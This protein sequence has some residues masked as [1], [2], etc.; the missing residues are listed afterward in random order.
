MPYSRDVLD[1]KR[2]LLNEVTSGRTGYFDTVKIIREARKAEDGKVPYA[3]MGARAGNEYFESLEI[4]GADINANYLGN[5]S[6]NDINTSFKIG[7][8]YSDNVIDT[9]A[10]FFVSG[11]SYGS[12]KLPAKIALHLALNRLAEEEGIRI[13]MNTGEGG[14]LP[15]E[16]YSS[17][18][19]C[20]H[21]AMLQNEAIIDYTDRLLKAHN[22]ESFGK[23]Q[24]FRRLYPLVTQYASGR[25]WRDP[26]YL[27]NADAIEIKIGQGA[28]IGHGG[29]LPAEKVTD[30]V[31]ENRGIPSYRAAHSPSRH[32]DIL[33][34]EDLVAKVLEL[35]EITDWKKP[36]IVKIGASRVYDDVEI[37]LKSYA[38]AI[39]IDGY[40]GG[41]GAA[42]LEVRDGIGINTI[43]ALELAKDAITDYYSIHGRKYDHGGSNDNSSCKLLVHGGVWDSERIAKCIALGADGVGIGTGFMLTMG[44][45][46]VQD[47]YTNT[48]PA[49]LTGSFEKLDILSTVD[50]IVNYVK[51]TL[52]ELRNIARSL[53]K[54]SIYEIKRDN[55]VVTDE[56][57]SIVTELSFREG[58]G[59][60]NLIY[61][62]ITDEL[63]QMSSSSST[64]Q[65][66]TT[67]Q[68]QNQSDRLKEK[69]ILK[70]GDP[71]Y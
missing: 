7:G 54:K 17:A 46:L 12:L 40:V 2:R 66:S 24:L 45:T 48:C 10:P 36:I 15:W 5:N 20:S 49:G 65:P 14:A 58:R 56:L 57:A 6:R 29:L 61:Q 47:C 43:P 63:L 13:M 9:D 71:F 53:G 1:L 11:M 19:M 3:G 30:L 23:E 55:L 21:N 26:S 33:G 42:P 62:K 69:S 51:G 64:P 22:L 27:L 38:D 68:L 37:I 44:C 52:Q 59:Y 35:R 50:R 39:S 31:A 41:T 60:H 34:P 70:G 32:L 18:E 8:R 28:K 4:L 25:F 67:S 16:L